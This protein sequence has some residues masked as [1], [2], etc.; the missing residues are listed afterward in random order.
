M[1]K[2]ST[3]GGKRPNSGQKP[4]PKA[5]AIESPKS[6]G[7]SAQELAKQHLDLAIATLSHISANGVTEG[8]R[9]SAARAIVEIAKGGS[10][11]PLGKKQERQATA[12]RSASEGRFAS[13]AP[14]KLLL[15]H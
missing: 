7:L 12:E 3:H 8:A 5:P 13:P 15:I 4:K 6:S 9:V 10:E 2:K 11:E 1:K 14:P